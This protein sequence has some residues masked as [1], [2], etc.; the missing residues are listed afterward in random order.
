M[1]KV[2]LET[3]TD[4]RKEKGL[5]QKAVAHW[6]D[7]KNYNTVSQWES[8]KAQPPQTHRTKFIGYLWYQLGLNQDEQQFLTVWY[9]VMV[10]L[11]GWEE[12]T[13]AEKANIGLHTDVSTRTRRELWGVPDKLPYALVGRDQLIHELTTCLCIP[14]RIALYGT[15]GVGK[16]AL[17]LALAYDK[18]VQAYFPDGIIW[19]NLGK[20]ADVLAEL[21]RVG[22]LLGIASRA[23][24]DPQDPH[25]WVKTIAEEAATRSLLFVI[26]DAWEVE[27]ALSFRF[28]GPSCAYLLTTRNPEIAVVFAGEHVFQTQELREHEGLALLERIAPSVVKQHARSVKE[29]L[30][31]VGGLPMALVLVGNYL[32]IQALRSPDGLVPKAAFQRVD[33]ARDILQIEQPQAPIARHP[34]LPKD[35]KISV[36]AL[37]NIS[38]EELMPQGK[39]LLRMLSVFPAKPNTFSRAAALAVS[40][41]EANSLQP[42]Y[43]YGLL[44]QI[45][46]ERYTMHQLVHEYAALEQP[47]PFIIERLVAYFEQFTRTHKTQFTLLEQEHQNILAA[48]DS[49]SHL[50]MQSALLILVTSL[51]EYLEQRGFYSLATVYLGRALQSAQALESVSGQ[52]ATLNALGR[53]ER[54]LGNY[55]GAAVH[56]QE[57]L[58][59]AL[60]SNDTTSIC[61]SYRNLGTVAYLQGDYQEAERCWAS[62]LPLAIQLQEKNLMS[63]FYTNLGTLAYNRNDFSTAESY[64][65]QGLA[66][67]KEIG[68]AER[69]AGILQNLA[70]VAKR[71]DDY[72]KAEAYYQEGYALAKQEKLPAHLAQMLLGLGSIL[73][74]RGQYAE[75]RPYMKEAVEL[76]RE[77]EH[78]ENLCNALQ[79]LGF[80]DAQQ[81]DKTSA[82]QHYQEALDI[83]TVMGHPELLGMVL[84]SLSR[85]EVDTRRYDEAEMHIT[86]CLNVVNP[87]DFPYI[88]TTIKIIQGDLSLARQELDQA[89]PIYQAMH[90]VAQQAGYDQLGAQALWGLAQVA[91]GRHDTAH[92]YQLGHEALITLQKIGHA[93]Q[94]QVAD[95]LTSIGCPQS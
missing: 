9:E 31:A 73:S 4:L 64:H 71:V 54:H 93:L 27:H 35:A 81:N 67:A 34:S 29:V 77:T 79:Y 1:T 48:L 45:G 86:Q 53:I 36:Q 23:L 50:E 60:A 47:Y 8:G 6:F 21:N 80:V 26:D 78:R 25:V 74:Q 28:N 72:A 19:I 84:Y 20:R 56:L 94:Q 13:A 87:K 95:W 46:D 3:L 85:L 61:D 63:A 65:Q 41:E 83:A 30:R 57:A 51:S 91:H 69:V 49:A 75:A 32:R 82:I 70:N 62:G 16:T 92:A 89:E 38:V 59:L 18:R 2:I 12:L 43:E 15:P 14:N 39:L 55:P 58:R 17:A 76:A 66:L 68:N 88:W 22:A 7:L 42:L 90:D 40:L 10:S 33:H 5:S 11:W 52:I 37:V 44:E 24:S